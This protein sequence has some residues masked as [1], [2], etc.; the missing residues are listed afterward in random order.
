MI[1]PGLGEGKIYGM[2]F[3]DGLGL[4]KYE[5][6]FKE[7][8]EVI[9]E[10]GIA[11]RLIFLFNLESTLKLK[12]DGFEEKIE[13]NK[14]QNCILAIPAR[15]SYTIHFFAEEAFELNCLELIQPHDGNKA[16]QHDN[17]WEQVLHLLLENSN[18]HHA[19]CHQGNYSLK[20]VDLFREMESFE[21]D[22]VLKHLFFDAKAHEILVQQ[23]LRYEN[24]LENPVQINRNMALEA[25]FIANAS[26][27]LRNNVGSIN[28]VRSLARMTG[29]NNNKLQAGFKRFYGQTVNEYLNTVR[30]QKGRDFLINTEYN[31]S[32]IVDKI[33]LSSKSY[34]SKI[35]REQYGLSPSEFRKK[36][37]EAS[38]EI[39][40]TYHLK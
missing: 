24:D 5:G 23:L 22:G 18:D 4:I 36:M 2:N 27:V 15:I 40:Q 30:M 9:F 16:L 26:V 31:I 6:K 32:E 37:K 3:N 28:T 38:Q 11:S 1:S 39:S 10:A 19:Y 14:F 25:E 17:H 29:S 35:F 34:F 21:K 33:G 7:D 8:S 20:T 12:I 13:L